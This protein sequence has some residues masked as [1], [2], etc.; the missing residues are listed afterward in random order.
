M[1]LS[2]LSSGSREALTTSCRSIL[3][4]PQLYAMWALLFHD[5]RHAPPRPTVGCESGGYRSPAPR[6]ICIARV[7]DVP[8]APTAL[9]GQ[10]NHH[11][12]SME[13]GTAFTKRTTM[14]ECSLWLLQISAYSFPRARKRKRGTCSGA[15]REGCHAL[16]SCRQWNLGHAATPGYLR[17]P[18]SASGVLWVNFCCKEAG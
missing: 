11:L 13:Y 6:S 9:I 8:N 10:N 2:G 1:R 16:F 15:W 18:C 12:K 3:P 14:S 4:R 5:L 17:R 7:F